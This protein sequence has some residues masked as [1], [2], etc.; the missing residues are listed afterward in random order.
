M[1]G[2]APDK[3]K[4]HIGEYA[5]PSGRMRVVLEIIELN[6]GDERRTKT[7]RYRVRIT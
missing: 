3:M 5:R 6:R 4:P 7:A 2:K 1:C